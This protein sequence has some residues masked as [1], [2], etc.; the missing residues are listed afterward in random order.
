MNIYRNIHLKT[1]QLPTTAKTHWDRGKPTRSTSCTTQSL[2]VLLGSLYELAK[3]G[4]DLQGA[5]K[6]S[7]CSSRN[8]YVKAAD[9]FKDTCRTSLDTWWAREM[10]SEQYRNGQVY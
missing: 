8:S 6:Y 3:T 1:M 9:V 4:F 7:T 5:M 2:F 10:N